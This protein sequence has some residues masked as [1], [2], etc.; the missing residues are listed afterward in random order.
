MREIVE[1][2]VLEKLEGDL[3][4]CELPEAGKKEVEQIIEAAR[5][6][7]RR[8]EDERVIVTMLYRLG[9]FIGMTAAKWML[10]ELGFFDAAHVLKL[11]LYEY[12][13]LQGGGSNE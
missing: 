5:E 13:S 1:K 9:Y 4:K 3:K 12:V 6:V 7:L 2:Y 8:T 11:I 10:A